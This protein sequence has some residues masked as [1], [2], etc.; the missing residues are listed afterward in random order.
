MPVVYAP[1]APE[2]ELPRLEAVA[3]ELERI[4]AFLV[5]GPRRLEPRRAA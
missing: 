4:D 5:R 1:F 3:G 2:F